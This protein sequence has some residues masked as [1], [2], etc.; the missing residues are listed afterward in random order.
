MDIVHSR[1]FFESPIT[2]AVECG[3]LNYSYLPY[4]FI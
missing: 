2:C 4:C 3:G 1:E